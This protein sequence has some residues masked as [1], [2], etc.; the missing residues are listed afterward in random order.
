MLIII[1]S[2]VQRQT[3]NTTSD[4]DRELVNNDDTSFVTQ[5][6]NTS[7][8]NDHDCDNEG[9]NRDDNSNISLVAQTQTETTTTNNYDD[10]KKFVSS[11]APRI[12]NVL[13]KDII[14]NEERYCNYYA[15]NNS[16]NRSNRSNDEL[17]AYVNGNGNKW[18]VC[19]TDV[20]DLLIKW[21][22]EKPRPCTE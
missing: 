21:K 10:S 20:H 15:N 9:N 8:D 13:G 5:T 6:E 22:Q 4:N 2:L 7:S 11:L 3:W 1:F 17:D 16:H 12:E 19:D 14:S 18:I